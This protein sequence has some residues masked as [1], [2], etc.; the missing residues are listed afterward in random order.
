[1]C[2]DAPHSERRYIFDIRHELYGEDEYTHLRK[3]MEGLLPILRDLKINK[4]GI[5]RHMYMHNIFKYHLTYNYTTI[6]GLDIFFSNQIPSGVAYF[7]SGY[8]KLLVVEISPPVEE[9]YF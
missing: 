6:M 2:L 3:L 4:V 5:K 9:E 1:L 7:F 8:S